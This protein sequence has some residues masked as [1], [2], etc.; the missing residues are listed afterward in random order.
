MPITGA[1]AQGTPSPSGDRAWY[2]RFG[3]RGY[4]QIRYNRL[5]ESNPDLTCS[6][7]DR[8]IGGG[9]G[10]FLRRARLTVTVD[11]TPRTSVLV[12]IDYATESAGQQHTLQVR[13]AF[14]DIFLDDDRAHRLR[15]GQAKLPFG[16]ETLQ[17]SSRRLALDRS[18]A[19]NSGVPNERDLGVF[20]LWSP[21]P[22]R[23]RFASIADAGLKGSGDYGVLNVGIYNGQ[24]ANRAEENDNLHAVARLAWPFRLPSGQFLELG[25]QGYH[26]RYVVTNRSP[27]V[28]GPTEFEDERAAI[29]AILYPQPLG[30]QAEWN[31]GTGPEFDPATGAIRAQRLD[32]GYVQLM[33]RAR[34]DGHTVMPFFRYQLYDGGRKS[35]LDARAH[36]VREA[37]LGVEWAPASN[38]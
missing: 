35:E 14:A 33:Y 5:L 20:W 2:E 24:G 27:S 8:S 12:E 10:F 26:G 19:I 34:V 6:A 37:E 3:L 7:C 16:F 30:I 1:R 9:N 36:R 18:D 28:A 21:Q 29:S 22:A 32:G 17:S 25:V 11:P 15:F 38:L 23:D 13:T 31:T 4:A